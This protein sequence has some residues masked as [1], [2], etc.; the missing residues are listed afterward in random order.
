MKTD[1][2]MRHEKIELSASPEARAERLR[3]LRNLANLS[4]KEMCDGSDIKIDTL[5]GWE[6]ARHG[7]LSISGAQKIIARIANEGVTCTSEWLLY[8]VGT[9]PT[10]TPYFDKIKASLNQQIA[11]PQTITDEEKLIIDELLLFRTHHKD[12]IDLIVADDGM[13]THYAQGDYVAG[14]KRY[15][16]GI[17]SLIGCDCIVQLTDGKILVRSLRAGKEKNR[18]TLTCINSQTTVATPLLYDVELFCAAPV[19]WIRK[20]DPSIK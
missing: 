13:L 8:D 7:G 19:I 4:R 6:V 11:S 16:E 20:K 1:I 5:I 10:L 18:F 14:I 12:T 17:L 15:N 2:A 3:R 9:P